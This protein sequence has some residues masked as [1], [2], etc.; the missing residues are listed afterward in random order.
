MKSLKISV[1]E[2]SYTIHRLKPGA[3]IPKGITASPFYSISGSEEELSIVAPDAVWVESEKS[4][5]DWACLKINGPLDFEEVGILA[6]ISAAL[7]KAGIS[8]FAVSTFNTDYILVKQEQLKTAKEI[9]TAEGHKFARPV[10][11]AL[12]DVRTTPTMNAYAALLERQF[13]LIKS[14]LLEKVG[15]AALTALRSEAA[16]QAAVGGLYEFM[17]PPVRLIVNRDLFVGYCVKNLDRILPEV[18]IPAKKKPTP[19]TK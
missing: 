12:V 19:K 1:L 5:P 7:A 16:L 18:S 13:P 11:S 14:L 8:L 2:G 3:G 6:G 10:R 17:P 4:E 15:P 9:L